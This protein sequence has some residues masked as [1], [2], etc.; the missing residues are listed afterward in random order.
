MKSQQKNS[1]HP[2]LIHEIIVTRRDR[3]E[4]IRSEIPSHGVDVQRRRIELTPTVVVDHGTTA[5]IAKVPTST[6]QSRQEAR[7]NRGRS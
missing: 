2:P 4:P 7:Q 3:P 6:F 5:R 1:T